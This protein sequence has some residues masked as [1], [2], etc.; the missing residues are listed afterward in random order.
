MEGVWIDPVTAQLMIVVCILYPLVDR[1]LPVFFLKAFSACTGKLQ[2][3]VYQRFG[4]YHRSIQ[5]CSPL[6]LSRYL[7]RE[8]NPRLNSRLSVARVWACE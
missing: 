2:S 5:W 1:D 3:F 4:D 6:A 8:G 7:A